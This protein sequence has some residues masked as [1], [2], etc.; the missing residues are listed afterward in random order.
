[1]CDKDKKF[2]LKNYN[3]KSILFENGVTEISEEKLNNK[4]IKK[5]IF[6]ILWFVLIG[7]INWQ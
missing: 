6:S 7:L 4:K 2:I 5:Q 1:M 3:A